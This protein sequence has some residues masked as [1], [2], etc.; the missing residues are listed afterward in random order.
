[1]TVQRPSYDQDDHRY[2]TRQVVFAQPFTLGT[3]P[4]VYP[5]GTYTVETKSDAFQAGAQTGHVRTSTV[6]IIPTATGVVCR[7]IS[8]KDLDGALSADEQRGL[9]ENPDRGEADRGGITLDSGL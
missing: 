9:S 5:A 8:S 4:E 2:C 3:A 6:L 1:M 7:E